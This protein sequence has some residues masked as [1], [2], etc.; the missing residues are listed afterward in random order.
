MKPLVFGIIFTEDTVVDDCLD[1]APFVLLEAFLHFERNMEGV[2]AEYKENFT[3]SH[4][5]TFELLKTMVG[6]QFL[7]LYFPLEVQLI[8]MQH[9]RVLPC[10][11]A[12][13]RWTSGPCH[14]F[15]KAKSRVTWWVL[16]R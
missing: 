9:V 14:A 2:G 4:K 3:T 10:C 13:L 15:R 7:W 6:S 1:K 11:H 8:S 16:H 12:A 5:I